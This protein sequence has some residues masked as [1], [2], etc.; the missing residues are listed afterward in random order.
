MKIRVVS[1]RGQEGTAGTLGAGRVGE[2]IVCEGLS[3]VEMRG[4]PIGREG[5]DFLPGVVLQV[6]VAL[7]P[8]VQAV[9]R[10]P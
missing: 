6:P 3:D 5:T 8:F 1:R 4:G 7:L 10:P 9:V 2:T